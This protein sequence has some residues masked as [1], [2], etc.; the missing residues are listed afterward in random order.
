MQHSPTLT[1]PPKLTDMLH[2]LHYQR[3]RILLALRRPDQALQAY[4]DALAANPRYALAA[5]SAGFLEASREQW[6]QAAGW[7]ERALEIESDNAEHWFN[8]GFVQ[9]QRQRDE[10]AI[11]CFDRA[12]ALRRSLDRAWF[13]LGISHRRRGDNDKAGAAFKVAAELQPMNPHAFYELAMVRLAQNDLKDVHRIIRHVSGFDPV[14]TRQLVRETGQ[15][16]E[17]VELR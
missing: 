3:A 13:G 15:H 1:H 17:G 9:Q 5:A 6:S 12:V 8:L 10:E 16:P 11:R 4:A 7:F 2:W 14:M